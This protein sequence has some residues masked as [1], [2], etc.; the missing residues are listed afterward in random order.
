MCNSP[1]VAK[2][3]LRLVALK[4]LMIAR[5]TSKDLSTRFGNCKPAKKSVIVEM[6]DFP[7][8]LS[9]HSIFFDL[10]Y[11]GIRILFATIRKFSLY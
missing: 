2:H 6:Q 3:H 11:F 8:G 9:W 5:S 4:Y 1:T 7:I 10:H